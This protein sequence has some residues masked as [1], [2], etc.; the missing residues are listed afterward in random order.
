[1]TIQFGPFAAAASILL[2]ATTF[3]AAQTQPP[4]QA[5][6][7]MSPVCLQLQAQLTSLDRGNDDPR[8]AELIRRAED[9][10]NRQQAQVNGLV[11]QGRRNDCESRG[12]FSIFSSP[13]PQCGQ[14]NANIQRARD[15]LEQM[16]NQLEQLRGGNTERAAQR[17]S[18]IRALGDNN[19]GPQYQQAARQPGG[20][21]DQLF[22]GRTFT[23][24]MPE[25]QQP[26]QV[27]G[28]SYRTLCVRTCDGYY[29]PI[30]FSAPASRFADDAQACQRMCPAAQVSLYAYH[31]PGEDVNQAVSTVDGSPYTSLPTAFEY[32]KQYNA[33][34][35]CRRAGQ[36]WADAMKAEGSDQTVRQGD[37]VVNDDSAK[38]MSQPL[39]PNG[40]PLKPAQATGPAAMAETPSN[41]P[42][43]HKGPVRT[44][45]PTFYPRQ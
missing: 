43:Q 40:K 4:P 44:V 12:F 24:G 18:L 25:Q 38:K 31:N 7:P 13:P 17:A 2:A 16:Q 36:S 22:G 33:A 8:R 23:P 30:S 42:D 37:I 32:R 10:T 26:Q 34:C 11:D 35:S 9:A 19:C 5:Q 27:T 39:G 28:D 29:F 41:I 45:G 3:A 21:L 6:P 1:M 15:Q 14:I 20:F